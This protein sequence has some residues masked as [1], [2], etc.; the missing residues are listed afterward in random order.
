[1]TRFAPF[2]LL[3]F[4]SI[5][6]GCAPATSDRALQVSDVKALSGNWLGYAT[7]TGAGAPNPIEL[8]INPDG[9]WTSRTGAQVQTGVVS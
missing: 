8:T 6:V 7:E 3:V 2:V 5:G 9:T 1:M 4:L